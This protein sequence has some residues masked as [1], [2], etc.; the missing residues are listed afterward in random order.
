MTVSEGKL[1]RMRKYLFFI[2]L[3]W[4]VS[5]AA[6]KDSTVVPGVKPIAEAVSLPT[7]TAEF[8]GGHRA[9]VNEILKNFKTAPLAKAGIM[10]A[11]VIATFIVDTEGKMVDIKIESYEHPMVKNEFLRTLKMVKIPWIPAEQNGKKVRSIMRQP[12]I[13][14]L[15]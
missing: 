1:L 11:K 10:N 4:I 3:F 8:P 15:Q 2:L 12:L 5:V 13:F 7:T 14:N 9:F 6:Q